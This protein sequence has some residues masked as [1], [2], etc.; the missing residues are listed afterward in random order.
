MRSH[1]HQISDD[2]RTWTSENDIRISVVNFFQHLIS[3]DIE[4]WS[5]RSLSVLRLYPPPPDYD[6]SGLF[7]APDLSEIKDAV[8][9]ID[10]N[11][12]ARPDG[13]SSLFYQYYWDFV[14]EDVYAAVLDFF[15]GAHMARSFTT[16]TII[17]L[18]KKVNPLSWTDYR[19]IS[20]F[21]VT[22]KVISK[23]LTARLAP[24][25]PLV[26]APNQSGFVQGR[27]LCDNVLLTQ[28]MIHDLD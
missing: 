13:F 5:C 21:N 9:G 16:I 27:L 7:A 23:N 10:G 3:S 8:F 22:N 4:H 19:P 18:T 2:D 1:I 17:L 25:L 26:L 24:L 15:G 14:C 11:S 6:T 28:E 12:C 20:L